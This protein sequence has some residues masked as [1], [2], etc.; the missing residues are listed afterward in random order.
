[1]IRAV[2]TACAWLTLLSAAAVAAQVPADAARRLSSPVYYCAS[3]ACPVGYFDA[4]GA[5][6]AA[7]ELKTA[8]YPKDPGAPICAC[9]GVS[10]AAVRDEAGRGQRD[11][12]RRIVAAAQSPEARCLKLSPTGRSCEEEVRRLFLQHFRKAQ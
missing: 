11:L 9:L 8:A 7:A 1:V 10:A 6:V 3:A 2:A 4:W 5:S 12:V